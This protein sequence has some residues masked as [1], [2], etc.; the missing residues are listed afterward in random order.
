MLNLEAKKHWNIGDTLHF[1]NITP[2]NM[3]FS[4]SLTSLLSLMNMAT[5]SNRLLRG[6]GERFT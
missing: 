1:F 2:T 6:R 3:E 4:H 5:S